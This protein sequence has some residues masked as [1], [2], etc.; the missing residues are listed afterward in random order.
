[1][2]D[3]FTLS[4]WLYVNDYCPQP[5]S[6][7]FCSII[8]HITWDD[9]YATPQLYFNRKGKTCSPSTHTVLYLST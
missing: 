2:T 1:L 5:S 4:L 7:A 8:Q 3:R 6:I 9:R